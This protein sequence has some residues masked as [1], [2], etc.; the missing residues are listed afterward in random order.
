MADKPAAQIAA[1][2]FEDGFIAYVRMDMEAYKA[3]LKASSGSSG[4]VDGG[5]QSLS[6]E[7]RSRR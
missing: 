7:I 2:S 3:H 6:E 5:W 1:P 4:T